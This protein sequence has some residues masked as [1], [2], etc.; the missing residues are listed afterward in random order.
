MYAC[1]KLC[2]ALQIIFILP[3]YKHWYCMCVME[4]PNI[5]RDRFTPV[6]EFPQRLSTLC[7]TTL[8]LINQLIPP[9][10]LHNYI[11]IPTVHVIN[12]CMST[13]GQITTWGRSCSIWGSRILEIFNTHLSGDTSSSIHCQTCQIYLVPCCCFGVHRVQNSL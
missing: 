7:L 11:S 8:N 9:N 6:Y 10:P 2:W 12:S 13:E 3:G 5:Y 1:C 4:N